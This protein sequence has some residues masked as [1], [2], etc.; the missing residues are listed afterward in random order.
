MSI[1]TH[2]AEFSTNKESMFKLT[3]EPGRGTLILD[4]MG[5]AAQQCVFL[6]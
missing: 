3:V 2:D 5:C 6:R 1:S 4:L